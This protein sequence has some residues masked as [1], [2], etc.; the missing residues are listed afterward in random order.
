M[1]PF[2]D[3]LSSAF[4]FALNFYLLRLL[5]RS[6]SGLSASELLRGSVLL[7]LLGATDGAHTS[8]GVFTEVGAVAVL[9]GLA[10]Y[11]LVDP[12]P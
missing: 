4:F 2:L 3:L 10:C 11:S 12:V 5:L 1:R 8:N 6:L 7:G 9:G